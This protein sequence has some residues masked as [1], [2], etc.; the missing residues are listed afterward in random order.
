MSIGARCRPEL[1][2]IPEFSLSFTTT[3]TQC[4]K[5]PP[6]NAQETRLSHGNSKSSNPRLI[7]SLPFPMRPPPLGGL[8]PRRALSERLLTRALS[9][10]SLSPPTTSTR[11]L[12]A[13]PAAAP[14]WTCA[15][16]CQRL[17]PPAEARRHSSSSS[18]WK[19]RQGSDR[20]AREAKVAGLKS[21]AAFKL[22]EVRRSIFFLC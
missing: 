9:Q 3:T 17:Y 4:S 22:L 13:S 18:Q 15:S 6:R 11:P 5:Q 12:H 19:A 2:Y 20:F 7:V 10:P 14:G 21:R 1:N 16:C 8:P